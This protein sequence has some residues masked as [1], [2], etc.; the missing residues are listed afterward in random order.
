[1]P[2]C[3]DTPE[4]CEGDDP[5]QPVR[6]A[7]VWE[8]HP[9]CGADRDDHKQADRETYFHFASITSFASALDAHQ[10]IHR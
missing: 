9:N 2:Y 8:A 10:V 7:K 5:F 6:R 3:H 4:R 1:M